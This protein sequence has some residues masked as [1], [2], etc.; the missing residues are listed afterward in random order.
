MKKI[1][2]RIQGG[3]LLARKVGSGEV[4]IIKVTGT[5]TTF[6]YYWNSKKDAIEDLKA[7][8]A[9]FESNEDEATEHPLLRCTKCG[10]EDVLIQGV[11]A[12]CP[13]C[14]GKLE[15]VKMVTE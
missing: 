3:E 5:L 15:L 8:I 12:N 1:S 4:G 9:Y 11:F 7:V 6:G 2:D 10:F 13:K 14:G